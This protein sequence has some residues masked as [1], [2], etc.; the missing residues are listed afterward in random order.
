MQGYGGGEAGSSE[1]PVPG[2]QEVEGEERSGV[3]ESVLG[4]PLP[5]HNWKLGRAQRCTPTVPAL[6]RQRRLEDLEFRVNVEYI[7][8][9]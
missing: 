9:L 2:T 6:E 5:L 7:I 8:R 1:N 4:I 3:A